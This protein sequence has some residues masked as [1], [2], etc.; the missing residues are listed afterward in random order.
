MS[1]EMNTVIEKE[2]SCL[3]DYIFEHE[4]EDYFELTGI[5]PDDTNAVLAGDRDDHI[6][7]AAVKV[8][9]WVQDRKESKDFFRADV[10]AQV[11]C[12][13]RDILFLDLTTEG[14]VFNP[15]KSWDADTLDA[16]AEI[17][18]I[19]FDKEESNG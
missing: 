14:D 6:Y 1:N 11:L 16:I 7:T 13:I 18:R 2:I 4:S 12:R 3:T 19:H 17:I 9:R 8:W 10:A 5:N 15:D